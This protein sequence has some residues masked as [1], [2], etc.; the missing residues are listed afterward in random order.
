MSV[1]EPKIEVTHSVEH[2]HREA[3]IYW[4]EIWDQ[5]WWEQEEEIAKMSDFGEIQDFIGTL[6]G[7]MESSIARAKGRIN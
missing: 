1:G 2:Y 6:R 5:L 4:L 3:F 7:Q